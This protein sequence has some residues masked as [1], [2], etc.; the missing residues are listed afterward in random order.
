[1]PSFLTDD[2]NL[3]GAKFGW[4]KFGIFRRE[5]LIDRDIL[6]R[7]GAIKINVETEIIFLELGK[8]D[9]ESAG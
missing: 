7:I 2:D 8:F 6:M 1:M 4:E 3:F 5:R 9:A